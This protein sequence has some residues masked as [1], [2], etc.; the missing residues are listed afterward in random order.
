[1]S[2]TSIGTSGVTF[3]DSSV[4]ATAATGF[5]FK[6]RIINGAMMIDQRNVGASVTPVDLAYT[7]DRWS[8]RL[9]QASKFT[10]QQNAGSLT[11]TNLPVGFQNY[12]G[13]TVGAS[14]NVTV[15]SSD[16]FGFEQRIEGFN[17]A[18]LQWGTSNAKTVTLSFQVRSSVT[19]TF[20]GSIR[21]SASDYCYPFTYA[22]SSAN[23]WTSISITIAG[24]TSGTWIGATNGVGLT[25]GFSIGTG[26]TYSG[27]AN[28]W[29]NATYLAATGATN[30]ITTNSATLYITG[31]Q[32]EKGSTA[33]SFDFRP[34]G[35]ELALC[36][37]YYNCATNQPLGLAASGY[38]YFGE[39]CFP[40]TMRAAPTVTGS[41]VANNGGTVGT[42]SIMTQTADGFSHY[43]S[44]NN[45]S[46]N[47][48]YSV[49][50]AAP[51]EL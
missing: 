15:G 25:V 18:D 5:G 51:A 48:Q 40:V 34:Y 27:T 45:L 43:A 49:T 47:Y 32:L 36:K 4:Q 19:G 20:S 17:S 37:R 33:T 24:P 7:L 26:S 21:N 8:A 2:G 39:I 12:L 22:I 29:A 44:S 30:S 10:I 1:M 35:T 14:A 42:F 28:T 50:Y 31:V 38:G 46:V 6:N 41:Y 11:G 23:I 13:L 3:P 16:Y 9:S